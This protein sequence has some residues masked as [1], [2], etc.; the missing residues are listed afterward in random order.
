MFKLDH[1]EIFELH[2]EFTILFSIPKLMIVLKNIA[3]IEILLL[4]RLFLL[5]ENHKKK[6]TKKN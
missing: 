3:P 5:Y 4:E 6:S 2:S 1:Y